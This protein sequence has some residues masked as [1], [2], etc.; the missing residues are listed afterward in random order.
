M[1]FITIRGD[2]FFI[3]CELKLLYAC[4]YQFISY[5]RNYYYFIYFYHT[6]VKLAFIAVSLRVDDTWVAL[7]FDGIIGRPQ[8][9]RNLTPTSHVG[10]VG[11]FLFFSRKIKVGVYQ[12]AVEIKRP[13]KQRYR[14]KT[15]GQAEFFAARAGGESVCSGPGKK[16][17]KKSICSVACS[18]VH[19]FVQSKQ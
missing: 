11:V 14:K 5:T 17:K 16:K 18:P 19:T 3:H 15:K 10:K 7:L 1:Q 6:P 12:S 2:Q 9:N 4:G 13:Q 8:L